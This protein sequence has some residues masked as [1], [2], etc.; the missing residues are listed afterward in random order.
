MNIGIPNNFSFKGLGKI[1]I[2]LGKNGSGKSTILKLAEAAHVDS[3]PTKFILSS[4]ITPERGGMLVYDPSVE[5]QMPQRRYL[6]NSRKRN[7]F[8]QFKQQTISQYTEL[9]LRVL[10]EISTT[11]RDDSSYTFTKYIDQINSL[12]ENIEIRPVGKSFSIYQ[13]T[14]GEKIDPENISSGESEL[15]SLAIE[16]LFFY[17]R[18]NDGLPKFLLLDEPDVHLHPDLQVRLMRFIR[19][20]TVDGSMSVIVV[21]HSTP[22]LGALEETDDLR[23]AFMQPGQKDIEFNSVDK[24]YKE[25]LP[26][27]GAHPLSNI[28]KEVPLF[29]VEG[30]DDERIWQ[31]AIRSSSGAIKIY[32]CGCGGI[33][34]MSAYETHAISIIKSVYDNAR[35]Y[36][37]RDRDDSSGNPA[38]NAP[39]IKMMLECRNAENLIVTDE[40]L[41]NLPV[42]NWAALEVKI[43][44]WIK[45]TTS[46]EF[47]DDM[48]AFKVDGYNRKTFN[49]KNIRNII[50]DLTGTSKPWEVAVGQTIGRMKWDETVDFTTPSSL[51]NFLGEKLV[52]QILPKR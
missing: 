34:E 50:I 42:K 17:V 48:K 11:R 24:T 10:R 6:E 8:N 33:T 13:K 52:K 20:L 26:I 28:F 9:E 3:D 4:Y 7:Q 45:V 39:L 46:H 15:I 5:Q 30:E 12:L 19:D 40:V 43:D 31:S 35:A 37:L 41:A 22:L 32:P 49:L 27:F 29:L 36:S 44:E 2:L 16:C 21:T 23:V 25:L 1:N 38:D 47:L 18:E 51:F 14:T